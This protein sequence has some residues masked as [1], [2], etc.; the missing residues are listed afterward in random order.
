MG[1]TP[2]FEP[3]F[4]L[5]A[6]R[7]VIGHLHRRLR[8]SP[9]TTPSEFT[10]GSEMRRTDGRSRLDPRLSAKVVGLPRVGGLHHRYVWHEAASIPVQR[11]RATL[12]AR[13]SGRVLGI[14]SASPDP[15]IGGR[16]SLQS[17][18]DR[19]PYPLLCA[20]LGLGLGWLP[21]L[22]HGPIPE[23]FNVLYIRGS[24]AIWAFYAPRLSI[25]LLVGISAWPRPWWLRGPLL[26]ALAM[27]SPSLL[28]LATPRCGF[29]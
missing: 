10:R 23:K 14:H 27:L 21:V 25:G 3:R 6:S 8:E 22:V 24:I 15:I 4:E 26:G 17:L 11:A 2:E 16:M 7:F 28:A 13:T 12:M 20:L 9:T 19:V 18:R 5:V 1:S 29:T